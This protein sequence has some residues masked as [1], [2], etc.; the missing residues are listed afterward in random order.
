VDVALAS[1]H[2]PR[3]WLRWLTGGLAGAFSFALAVWFHAVL[4]LAE[5]AEMLGAVAEGAL[6]GLVTGLGTVWVM[7]EDHPLWRTALEVLAVIVAAGGV[8]WLADTG[9]IGNAFGDPPSDALV[10][11][12]GVVMPLCVIGAALLSRAS[13][14][15]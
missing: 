4:R 15:E 9:L 3:R 6:W 2:G 8:L 13:A 7:N 12:A 11:L 10:G 14:P 5:P 1:Y